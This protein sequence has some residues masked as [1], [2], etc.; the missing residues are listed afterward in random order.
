MNLNEELVRKLKEKGLT[1]TTM[2]S[3]TG[4]ALISKITD[5]EGASEVTEGGYVTYS[6]KAKIDTGVSKEIIDEYGVYSL[7]T[8][9]EM[10]IVC[11]NLKGADIGIGITGSL[12]NL[13][14]YNKDSVPCTVYFAICY[15]NIVGIEETKS[16]KLEV[17]QLDRY[18]QKGNIVSRILYTLIEIL[19]KK[20]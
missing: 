13:D 6:N 1:I 5:V 12:N 16:Y 14:K 15:E 3:C 2:E 20:E 11:K 18:L 17:A 8:S 19:N 10:A 4:G 9:E 7:E